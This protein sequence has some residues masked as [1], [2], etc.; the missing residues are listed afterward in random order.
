MKRLSSLLKNIPCRT[1]FPTE[2]E[3]SS[4]CYNS[5][6]A[7]D[8]SLFVCIRGTR[9]D[10]H[11]YA[12]SAY[13]KGA[14]VF[15]CEKELPLPYDAVQIITDDCRAALADVSAE[16]FSHPEKEIKIIGI[17][18]TKGKSTVAHMVR[19]ILESSGI[20]TG[21][22]G[23]CGIAFGKSHRPTENTTPESYELF[24]ALR[25]M[26][27]FG[28]EC[29]AIE[30][31]SQAMLM[32]RVRGIPFFATVMTNLY[33][34]HIGPGEHPDFENYKNCKKALF[35]LSERAVLN[36]DDA[37][38]NEFSAAAKGKIIT[39]SINSESDFRASELSSLE[40][41]LGKGFIVNHGGTQTPAC[42]PFPSDFSVYN[43]LAAI[44]ACSLLGVNVKA[45]A[46]ALPTV[47]VPGRFETVSVPGSAMFVIDY[48]H[49]GES[50]EKA[51]DALK[52]CSPLRLIC[53]FGSVGCRTQL[54]RRDL[55][56][57]ASHA[58]FCIITSDNPDTES[59]EKIIDEIAGNV[60]VPYIK[61]PS[62]ENAIK[63]A[64]EISEAG[65]IVLLAG[66]GHENYQ[67]INGKKIPFNE[68]EL[69][70][71]YLAEKINV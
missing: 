6:N 17:T 65:D 11:N 27:D 51:I 47:S 62:R 30:V 23:T 3:I 13:D 70:M 10:G 32:G 44:A 60:T 22:I 20:K 28:C 45:C 16:F 24:R 41:A 33:P 14:R 4:V 49:N 68:R 71:K 37:F 15:L 69:V 48:A 31:S 57:A 26:A 42:I 18:G 50:L 35:S 43:S 46:D 7:G 67:L 61:F 66:K 25:E 38:Y 5:N 12:R 53:L 40:N 59:P 1:D 21:L 56:K 34:D 19:H 36:A 2:T 58:D 9:T 55:G 52:E 54:R 8:G 64:V 39:Y 29:A 63:Y